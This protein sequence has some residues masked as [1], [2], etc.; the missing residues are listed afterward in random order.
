MSPPLKDLKDVARLK[1]EVV[2]KCSSVIINFTLI[3]CTAVKMHFRRLG[4]QSLKMGV[5][6]WHNI[7][8]SKSKAGYQL[9]KIEFANIKT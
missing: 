4:Q 5:A 8:N 9:N 6:V 2:Q 7:Y 1:Y 3:Q